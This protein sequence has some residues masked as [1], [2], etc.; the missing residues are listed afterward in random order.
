[1]GKRL[2]ICVDNEQKTILVQQD[3]NETESISYSIIDN[4]PHIEYVDGKVGKY[5]IDEEGNLVVIYSDI[6]KT[7]IELLKDE[8]CT[9]REENESI[10]S[11]ISELTQI[12]STL[13]PQ[14]N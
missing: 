8:N 5:A 14:T 4:P 1:M 7:D 6:P 2:L 9:L 13:V 11:A 10:K 3:L 12:I